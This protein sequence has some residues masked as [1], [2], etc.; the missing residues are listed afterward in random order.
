MNI[1]FGTKEADLLKTR[2]I[3]LELDTVTI[4]SSN[5]LTLYCAVENMPID[6]ISM[7]D[8]LKDLHH[9]LIAEY[10]KK[11][12]EFCE[13]AI[14]HL[15]GRWGKELDSFYDILSQRIVIFKEKDPGED[16]TGIVAK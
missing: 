7:L 5:P 3:I 11:N 1:I 9:N 14:S 10:K 15:L 4:K 16:W 6:E 2:Y 8:H 12:W 13:Q